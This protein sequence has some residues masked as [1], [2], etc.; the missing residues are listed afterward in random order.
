[1][2]ASVEELVRKDAVEVF[3]NPA[4]ENITVDENITS[5]KILNIKGKVLVEAENAVSSTISVSD[6]PTGKYILQ[7]KTT[8]GEFKTGLFIKN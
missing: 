2:P 6:L 8:R 3:P 4:S 1:M 5:Y 7:Y